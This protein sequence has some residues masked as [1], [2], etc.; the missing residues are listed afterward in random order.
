MRGELKVR[1]PRQPPV[2]QGSGLL[3]RS[4]LHWGQSSESPKAVC[5]ADTRKIPRK[6]P[7]P[8]SARANTPAL[9]SKPPR[10]LADKDCPW[11]LS[12]PNT[13]LRILP[14]S[15]LGPHRS[16]LDDAQANHFGQPSAKRK[17]VKVMAPL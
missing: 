4:A 2:L 16:A 7:Q 13:D 15:G 5:E 17:G 10:A 3:P 11:G 12:T 6:A 9:L 8:A 1:A 14:C